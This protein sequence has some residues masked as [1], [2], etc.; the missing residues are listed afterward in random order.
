M[1]THPH[2]G[3]ESWEALGEGRAKGFLT[4]LLEKRLRSAGDKPTWEEACQWA[5][6]CLKQASE[7]LSV[8]DVELALL[9]RSETGRPDIEFLEKAKI[10]DLIMDQ[11][12]GEGEL[13]E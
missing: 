1:S 5:Y 13:S 2:G 7:S 10:R 9:R 12:G 6:E 3:F 8:E 4:Q 11:D